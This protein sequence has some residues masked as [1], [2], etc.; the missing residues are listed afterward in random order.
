V[1]LEGEAYETA[2]QIAISL[3]HGISIVDAGAAFVPVALRC[4]SDSEKVLEGFVKTT[5]IQ[6][7]ILSNPIYLTTCNLFDKMIL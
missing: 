6:P 7:E 5:K 1:P 3:L 2:P 4:G